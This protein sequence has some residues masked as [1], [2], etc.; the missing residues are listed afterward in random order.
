M[1][2]GRNI[3]N[4]KYII[5]H[6]WQYPNQDLRQN[7][8]VYTSKYFNFD[9]RFAW[10]FDKI[11]NYKQHFFTISQ[12]HFFLKEAYKRHKEFKNPKII[13]YE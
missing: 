8:L 12:S 13:I 10:N 5:S 1:V 6:S 7:C 9:N 3:L 11:N 2:A 4:M